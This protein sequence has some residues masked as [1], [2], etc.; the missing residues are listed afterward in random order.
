MSILAYKFYVEEK[1]IESAYVVNQILKRNDVPPYTRAET[2]FNLGGLYIRAG[3]EYAEEAK[4]TL[5][6]DAILYNQLAIT[7][8]SPLLNLAILIMDEKKNMVRA[9]NYI[10]L[11][12]EDTRVFSSNHKIGFPKKCIVPLSNTIM[13]E[14]INNRVPFNASSLSCSYHV[15]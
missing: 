11:A 8:N 9:N 2:L 10:D 14:W 7:K 15:Y 13:P 12:V 3:V 1:Y 5:I 6:K 4:I